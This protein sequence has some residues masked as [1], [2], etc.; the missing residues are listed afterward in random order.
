MQFAEGPLR[1]PKKATIVVPAV[2]ANE[3]KKELLN[4]E[5]LF[6]HSALELVDNTEEE[7]FAW[8]TPGR[9]TSIRKNDDARNATAYLLSSA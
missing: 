7:A 2:V 9:A 6:S 8:G 4:N 5:S 3:Q 1:H